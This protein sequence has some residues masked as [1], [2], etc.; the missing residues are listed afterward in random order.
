MTVKELYDAM[1]KKDLDKVYIYPKNYKRYDPPLKVLY[2]NTKIPWG[3]NEADWLLTVGHF[4]VSTQ[5]DFEEF[6]YGK[7]DLVIYL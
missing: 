1:E 6:D 3:F 4:D 7:K 5:C 2:H